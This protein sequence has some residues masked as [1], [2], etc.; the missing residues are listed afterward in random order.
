MHRE[1]VKIESEFEK[2]RALMEQKIVYLEKS[3]DEKTSK[4]KDYM[5]KWNSHKSELST[6]IRQVV[7]KY[8]GEIKQISLQL[9]EE[10]EKSND[11]ESK[12]ADLQATHDEKLKLWQQQEFRLKQMLE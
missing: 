12:L 10:K 6:E 5:Q 3:L 9:E 4:E 2:E 11:L 7:Q 8:E 1:N